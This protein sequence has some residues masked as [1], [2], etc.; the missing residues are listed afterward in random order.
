MC[1]RF[2]L[3]QTFEKIILRF[4]ATAIPQ[5]TSIFSRMKEVR[6]TN[7]IPVITHQRQI[8]CLQWGL[9][10]DWSKN[11][12][13]NARSET[14]DKKPTFQAIIQNRCLIPATAYYEWR[15]KENLK[16]KTR[17]YPRNLGLMSFAGLF[18]GENFTI[19]TCKATPSVA[20][21][22][23]RMPVILNQDDEITWLSGEQPFNNV[24][25]LLQTNQNTSLQIKEMPSP[26]KTSKKQRDLFC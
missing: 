13:I 6:P 12:I 18:D 19:I 20:H 5:S 11:P 17:I 15:Q 1:S 23:H 26:S 25:K 2:E 3:N 9:K 4:A 10:A 24:A 7:L 8:T 14:L 16:I 22:H 21:V